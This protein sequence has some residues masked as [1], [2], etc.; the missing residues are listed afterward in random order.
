MTHIV[1]AQWFGVVSTALALGILFH[2]HD[3]RLMAEKMIEGPTGYIM[4]GVLPL[5]MGTLVLVHAPGWASGW[6]TVLHLIA[7]ILFVMGLFRVWGVGTWRRLLHRHVA[8]IPILF[9]LFG[10][11]FGLLM[12]YIGYVAHHL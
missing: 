5:L 3:A 12:L 6:P 4:G 11:I 2:L 9:S 7:G 8:K 10:L 1:L